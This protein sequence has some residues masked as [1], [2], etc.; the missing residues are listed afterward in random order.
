[1][2]EER[3][4]TP[5]RR[6]VAVD[7]PLLAALDELVDSAR[8]MEQT[9]TMLRHRAAALREARQDGGRWRDVVA[10]EERPLIAEMLTDKLRRFEGAGTRFRQAKAR[11]LYEDGMTME[12][13]AEMF[14]VTRQRISVLLNAT[15]GGR[16]PKR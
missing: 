14:G 5:S 9:V 8:D 7:D 1:M 4:V 11:A 12:Q 2:T 6:A 3:P 13:I 16:S 15:A 10:G